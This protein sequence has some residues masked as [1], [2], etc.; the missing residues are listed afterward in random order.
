MN[1]KRI[2][3]IKVEKKYIKLAVILVVIFL[4]II[5]LKRFILW[6]LILKGLF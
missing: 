1:I 4:I 6:V 2:K 5:Y 3:E